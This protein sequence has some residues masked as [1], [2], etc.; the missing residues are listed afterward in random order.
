MVRHMTWC[1]EEG[2][3]LALGGL[4]AFW[5]KTMVLPSK[6]NIS[7]VNVPGR[8]RAL[9]VTDASIP[10]T[11]CPRSVIFDNELGSA[12][13]ALRQETKFR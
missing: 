1:G 12:Q 11:N 2:E 6:P 5:M 9:T 13:G 7:H 8:N 3:S 4:A 10:F